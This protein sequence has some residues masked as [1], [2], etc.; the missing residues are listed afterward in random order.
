M[1]QHKSDH[2]DINANDNVILLLLSVLFYGMHKICM[3]QISGK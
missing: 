3:R 1:E 2:F